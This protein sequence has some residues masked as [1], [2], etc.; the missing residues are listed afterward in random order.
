[1]A[2][3][4]RGS[5]VWKA[6]T[7]RRTFEYDI[8]TSLCRTKCFI[9]PLILCSLSLFL[10]LFSAWPSPFSL[11]VSRSAFLLHSPKKLFSHCQRVQVLL[12]NICVR[13]ISVI[14]S[15]QLFALLCDLTLCQRIPFLCVWKARNSVQLW[16]KNSRFGISLSSTLI[17]KVLSAFLLACL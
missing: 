12:F 11:I 13:I 9:Q 17:S 14:F 8:L 5:Y 7:E 10:A 6:E 15:L 1:M 2:R 16:M 4:L 3:A